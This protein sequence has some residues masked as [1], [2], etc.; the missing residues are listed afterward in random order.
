[1]PRLIL[2]LSTLFLVTT[3]SAQDLADIL[4]LH[5]KAAE[6]KKME[7]VETIITSG[8]H[9][10]SMAGYESTFIKYQSR[11]NMVRIQGEI[12]G[13]QV[14]QTYNGQKGWMYAPGMGISEPKE[15]MEQE[16]E[17][18]LKQTEFENPLWNYREK[19]NSLDFVGVTKDEAEDHLRLTSNKGDVLNFFINRKTHLITSIKSQRIIG[20]SETEIEVILQEYKN[21]KGIPVAQYVVTKMNGET[22]TIV[23]IEKVEFNKK[24]DPALF[25]KP[26][27][28]E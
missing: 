3:T 23:D 21:V 14:I 15:M 13:S 10:Y 16:I 19:G 11:P 2:S 18:I 20:G 28:E 12:Q 7:K 26:T 8:K 5:F 6:Q 17:T 25:E 27:M 1:M 24:I 22:V 4:D 9:V